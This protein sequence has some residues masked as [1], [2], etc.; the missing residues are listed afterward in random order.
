MPNWRQVGLNYPCAPGCPPHH[1]TLPA[2]FSTAPFRLAAYWIP[3][4][5][6]LTLPN[7]CRRQKTCFFPILYTQEFC[8]ACGLHVI[9]QLEY[10]ILPS[11]NLPRSTRRQRRC[12]GEHESPSPRAQRKQLNLR[13]LIS[14]LRMQPAVYLPL[15][16]PGGSAPGGCR[17]ICYFPGEAGEGVCWPGKNRCNCRGPGR[18]SFNGCRVSCYT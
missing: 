17:T 13:C 14:P 5:H 9:T 12:R 11:Q 1:F 4:S 8:T 6:I 7:S 2:R 16:H 15:P 10:C 3:T 18:R